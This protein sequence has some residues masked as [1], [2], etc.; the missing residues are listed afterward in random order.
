MNQTKLSEMKEEFLDVLVTDYIAKKHYFPDSEMSG[1]VL[2]KKEDEIELYHMYQRG[3]DPETHK[4]IDEPVL[5]LDEKILGEERER[6]I[7]VMLEETATQSRTGENK[8][9]HNLVK[10]FLEK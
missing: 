4:E 7:Q 2:V 3:F 6:E 8:E 9:I 1:W 10:A 5:F